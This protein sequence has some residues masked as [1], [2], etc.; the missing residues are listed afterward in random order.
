M[1]A[2]VLAAAFLGAAATFLAHGAGAAPPAVRVAVYPRLAEPISPLYTVRVR[3]AGKLWTP[4]DVYQASVDLADPAVSA[5]ALLSVGGPVQVQVSL[6]S[7]RMHDAA[8]EPAS[9]GIEPTLGNGGATATFELPGPSNVSFEAD[10][11]RRHNLQLFASPLDPGRPRAAKGRHVVVLAAG[12]HDL[13]GDH[14]LRIPSDTTVYL[15]PGALVR[16]SL[17]VVRGAHDVVVR[18]D[19]VIDP[20]AYFD[21]SGPSAGVVVDHATRVGIRDVTILRGQNGGVTIA[22]SSDVTVSDVKEL[23]ADRYSDGV[24]IGSSTGVLIEGCFLRTSDDAIALWATNPFI[25]TGST[26]DVTVRDSV[27][28]PDVAHGILVGPY[29]RPDGSDAIENLAVEDVDVLEQ[30]VPQSRLYQGAI[31]LE[32]GDSLTERHLVFGDVR[33]ARVSRGEALDVHVYRNPNENKTAGRAVDDVLFRNVTVP[34]GSVS[35]IGGYGAGQGVTDVLFEALRRDGAVAG[36]A[37]AGGVE[38]E[39]FATGVVFAPGPP[40]ATWRNGHAGIGYRGRWAR[41]G[42]LRRAT[43]RGATLTV[44]F[45]GTEAILRGPTAADGGRASVAV[46]GVARGS[47]DA[48]ASHPAPNAVLFDTGALE[49]GTHT[50]TV[51]VQGASSPLSAGTGVALASVQVVGGAAR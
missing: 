1:K 19:G 23:N 2:R 29:G 18:G 21:S 17:T 6:R 14:V 41:T 48:Y 46:D 34:G 44:R 43:A 47:L 22:G 8:V 40:V 51:R 11:D 37:A 36:S 38:I 16:G 25:S 50:V 10:G 28:W 5:F 20:S 35:S 27:L 12:V 39:P 26:R 45:T 49:P 7:G 13:P 4:V 32:A 31:G 24:D 30:D 3:A 15:A 42:S 33:I 9:A